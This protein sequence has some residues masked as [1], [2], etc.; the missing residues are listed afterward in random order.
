MAAILKM[1]EKRYKYQDYPQD[2]LNNFGNYSN[3]SLKMVFMFLNLLSI[4]FEI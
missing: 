3:D 4:K 2:I 1:A